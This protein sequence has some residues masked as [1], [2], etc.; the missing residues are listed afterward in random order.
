MTKVWGDIANIQAIA[1]WAGVQPKR[2]ATRA[3][4]V[5][6]VPES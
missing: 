1:T 3:V 2:V 5:A 6:P 4:R